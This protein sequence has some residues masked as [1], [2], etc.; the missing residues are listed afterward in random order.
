MKRGAA[1][2]RGQSS[3]NDITSRE[4]TSDAENGIDLEIDALPRFTSRGETS[5]DECG[6]DLE[7]RRPTKFAVAALR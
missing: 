3:G 1:L 7:D 4:E 5:D 6:I 2:T